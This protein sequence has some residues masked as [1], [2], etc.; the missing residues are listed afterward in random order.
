MTD[1]PTPVILVVEDDP[2]IEGMIL[3]CLRQFGYRTRTAL[4]REDI[5]AAVADGGCAAIVLDLGLPSDDGVDI[6]RAL[7]RQSAVP[8]VMLTGRAGIHERVTGLEAGADDYIVKPFAGEELV[9]RLRAVLRRAPPGA[10]AAAPPAQVF[11]VG[12]V[13]V[14]LDAR[15]LEGPLGQQRLTEQ[16]ARLM[17]ALI[18]SAGALARVAAYRFVFERDWE[19]SD[20]ALDV[21][22]AHLRRK[23]REAGGDP[24]AIATMR[25]QGYLLRGAV[26]AGG[27][28]GDPSAPVFTKLNGSVG[29]DPG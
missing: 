21:H 16:E 11:R 15:L 28:R 23:I 6:A 3:R 4:R 29:D 22:V 8:I 9:A 19:P 13:R 7:R 2:T 27:P 25:G 18:E 24:E 12:A 1:A 5:M 14:A 10:A 26:P 17:R 20:R